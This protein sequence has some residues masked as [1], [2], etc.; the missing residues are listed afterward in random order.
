M[1]KQRRKRMSEIKRID[2]KEF[3]KE[4]FLLEANRQ[5]FHPLGLALEVIVNEE[6]GTETLGG[7][8]DYRDDPEGI[9]YD[10][11]LLNSPDTREKNRKIRMLLH[12]KTTVRFR[13]F[14]FVTQPFKEIKELI[15]YKRKK[16]KEKKMINLY[17]ALFFLGKVAA[18]VVVLAAVG[19]VSLL[20]L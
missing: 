1:I 8:W 19:L 6:D 14:G 17:G 12:E 15:E 18:V 4:G 11:D 2:I 10:D 3:R 13:K 16:E 7:V 9:L 5:F 20:V